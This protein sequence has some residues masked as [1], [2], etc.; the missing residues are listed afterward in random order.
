MMKKIVICV[1]FLIE[2]CL[3]LGCSSIEGLGRD[4]HSVGTS[5]QL[6]S[7]SASEKSYK[8]FI[9]NDGGTY[10][11]PISH[12]S[13]FG[14]GDTIWKINNTTFIQDKGS[15]SIINVKP[16]VYNV[17]G[18]RR[19]PFLDE[20]RSTVDIKSGESICLFVFNP[21]YG[22]ARI[23]SYKNVDCNRFLQDLNNKNA[24]Y[25]ID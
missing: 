24:T 8:Q 11:I 21:I 14:S 19:E 15:Y 18:N 17:F 13:I 23:T 22:A 5:I 6:S 16:G 20:K 4:I 9:P 12:Q 25:K 3:Q 1:F 10:L 7:R 2:T